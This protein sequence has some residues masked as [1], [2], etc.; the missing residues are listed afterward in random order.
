MTHVCKALQPA[1]F[2]IQPRLGSLGGEKEILFTFAEVQRH[3]QALM[4]APKATCLL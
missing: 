3:L 1:D 4:C 2:C